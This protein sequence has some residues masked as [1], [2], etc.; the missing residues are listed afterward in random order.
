M[1]S[2]LSSL[3]L[4]L[5]LSALVLV[6]GVAV[7]AA[8]LQAADRPATH[9]AQVSVERDGLRYE[10]DALTGTERLVDLSQPGPVRTNLVNERLEDAARLRVEAC[11]KLGIDGLD[12]LVREHRREADELRRLGYL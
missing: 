9:P 10:F 1:R 2:T 8:T 6:G 12:E 11:R 4:R 3:R 7:A 5:V